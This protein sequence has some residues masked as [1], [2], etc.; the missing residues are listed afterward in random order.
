MFDKLEPPVKEYR[1]PATGGTATLAAIAYNNPANTA[2]KVVVSARG[3]DLVFL[4]GADNSIVATNAVD[5]SYAGPLDSFSL[6]DGESYAMDLNSAKSQYL[7][8]RPV[9][10]TESGLGILKLC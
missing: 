1:I 7:S 5:G 3:C 9:N 6:S 10:D 8:I 2:R 4:F